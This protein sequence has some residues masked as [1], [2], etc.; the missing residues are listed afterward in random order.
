MLK[1]CM[2]YYILRF[3]QRLIIVDINETSILLSINILLF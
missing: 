3:F 2:L 1:K